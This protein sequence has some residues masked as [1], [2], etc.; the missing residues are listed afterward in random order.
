LRPA[1]DAA[2]LGFCRGGTGEMAP[3]ASSA[4]ADSEA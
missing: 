2:P 4:A 1:G 3:R